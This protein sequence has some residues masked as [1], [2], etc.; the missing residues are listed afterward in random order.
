[1][2]QEATRKDWNERGFSFGIFRDPPGQVWADFVHR[3]D[4]LVLL[5]EGEIEVEIEGK[6]ERPM[7]G[8]EVFIPAYEVHTV[9]NVGQKNNV[10]FHGY[11][12]IS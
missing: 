11:K 1:M 6:A 2:N 7:I 4:E 5:A 8:E 12:N 3:T 10:W 9:R